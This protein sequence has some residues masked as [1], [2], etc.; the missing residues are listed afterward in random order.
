MAGKLLRDAFGNCGS[1]F[2]A[3]R[4]N[5]LNPRNLSNV[6]LALAICGQTD[7][8]NR[9]VA[10]LTKDCTADTVQ[11]AVSPPP[12]RRSSPCT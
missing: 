3:E 10:V 6:A 8:A 1:R 12:S 2:P 7:Q 5:E 4:E 11:N 9:I